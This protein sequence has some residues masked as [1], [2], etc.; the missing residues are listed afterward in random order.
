MEVVLYVIYF[1]FIILFIVAI[2][3]ALIAVRHLAKT[4]K[5]MLQVHIE[6][7]DMLSA[8]INRPGDKEESE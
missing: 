4:H 5:E 6:I 2:L 3:K 7:K 1:G 8:A